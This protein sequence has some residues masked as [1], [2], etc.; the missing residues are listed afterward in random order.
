MKSKITVIG[1]TSANIENVFNGWEYTYII[2]DLLANFEVDLKLISDKLDL[3]YDNCLIIYSC[4][5]RN[6]PSNLLEYFTEYKNRNLDFNLFHISNE[7]LRHDTS[8]YKLAKNV[9]RNYFDPSITLNN[10]LTLPLGYKN[11]FFNPS[12][13]FKKVEDK[14]FDSCFVGQLKHDR[15]NVVHEI[16]NL[17][18]KFI[19]I[20]QQWDCPTSLPSEAVF[21][22]YQDTL[23]IPC[24]I[25]NVNQDSFRICE[26]LESGSIPLI[27]IYFQEDYFKHIFGEH[28]IPTV[29]DWNEIPKILKDIKNNS[30]EKILEINEWYKK[31][32]EELRAKIF[33]ILNK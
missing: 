2:K 23:L 10:V 4:D 31:F 3:F 6:I 13:T 20:T 33:N 22:I 27:K 14:K 28:P 30:N 16:S 15:I 32:K 8:Y 19:H 12:L 11:G 9:F 5:E 26:I 21:K 25:G 1:I 29:R 17:D 18:K 7:Q 24:P